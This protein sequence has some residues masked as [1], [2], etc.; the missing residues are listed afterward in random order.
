[1]VKA[2]EAK[3]KKKKTEVKSQLSKVA[4]SIV[5]VTGWVQSNMQ[6]FADRDMGSFVFA[7]ELDPQ[8]NKIDA[9]V[10]QL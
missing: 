1:M 3:L 2:L 7:E 10:Y 5:T 6:E 9:L 4:S 8:S